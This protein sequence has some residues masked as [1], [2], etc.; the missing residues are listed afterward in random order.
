M[1]SDF[2]AERAADQRRQERTDIDPDIEDRIGAVAAM[3]AR[4]IKTSDLCGDIRLEAAVAED[5][6]QER[7]EKKL[8]HRHQKVAYC[9]QRRADDDGTALAEYA[10]GQ[11]PAEDRREVHKSG[12]KAPDLRR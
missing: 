11:Q 5:E 9:H 8:L 7:E 10:V 6:K 3:I 1:K 4:R 2:L 12:V